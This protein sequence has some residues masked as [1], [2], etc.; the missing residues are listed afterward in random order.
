[1]ELGFDAFSLHAWQEHLIALGTVVLFFVAQAV[2][3]YATFFR[4]AGIILVSNV[5]PLTPLATLLI[6][7]IR[8]FR[9]A[10][11]SMPVSGFGNQGRLHIEPCPLS[12]LVEPAEPLRPEPMRSALS[13]LTNTWRSMCKTGWT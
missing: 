5:L 13:S 8:E 7:W 4:R 6:L 2:C 3:L 1:M 11:G 9:Y 12:M 10:I